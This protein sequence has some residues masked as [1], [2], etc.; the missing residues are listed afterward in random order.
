MKPRHILT[1]I[2]WAYAGVLLGAGTPRIEF[3]NPVFD[4]GTTARVQTVT[5]SFVVYN[6]GDAPLEFRGVRTSCG[7]TQA[8]PD[9]KTLLPEAT[10]RLDFS[11]NIGPSV[12]DI[13]EHLYVSSNDPQHPTVDL[14][15]KLYVTPL[16]E[17]TPNVLQLG[18]LRPHSVT[19]VVVSIS[20]ADGQR[21]RI[22]KVETDPSR[23]RVRVEPV[24][25]SKG[26]AARL[27]VR[28]TA[29]ATAGRIRDTISIYTGETYP[30]GI[31]KPSIEIDVQGD[32]IDA[33][34]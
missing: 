7:C 32:V 12:G 29:P 27:L 33:P 34:R 11:I 20:R 28:V 25:E 10:G 14:T 21:L 13:Q 4:F 3:D 15:L 24:R 17:V 26:Q 31:P 19:N 22:A 23:V 1:G 6:A 18:T 5:G 8:R 2:V 9:P 16:F 30:G